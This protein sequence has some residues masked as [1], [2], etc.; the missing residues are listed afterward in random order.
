M[1]LSKEE[2]EQKRKEIGI[3]LKN[4]DMHYD[5]SVDQEGVIEIDIELGDWKHDHRRLINLMSHMGYVLL[6]REDYGEDTGDDSYSTR[7][8]YF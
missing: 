6:D 5:F 2:I 7:Y 8:R 4:N 3:I 1:V